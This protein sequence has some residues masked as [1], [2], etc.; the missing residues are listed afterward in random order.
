MDTNDH[1]DANMALNL[2]SIIGTQVVQ[3]EEKLFVQTVAQFLWYFDLECHLF[4]EQTRTQLP[5]TK[6]DLGIGISPRMDFPVQKPKCGAA[7]P[8]HSN[9]RNRLRARAPRNSMPDVTANITRS[10]LIRPTALP[11]HLRRPNS[12]AGCRIRA[13]RLSQVEKSSDVGNR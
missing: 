6:T 8:L 5:R 9:F 4:Q 3:R 13:G 12:P 7:V 1:N 11:A 10:S 2:P